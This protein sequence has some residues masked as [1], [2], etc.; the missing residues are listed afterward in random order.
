MH[1]PRDTTRFGLTPTESELETM[2]GRVALPSPELDLYQ[3]AFDAGQRI[4]RR[5]ARRWQAVA[6]SVLVL[7]VAS[8][9]GFVLRSPQIDERDLAEGTPAAIRI[10]Q[11]Q[12]TVLV[13]HESGSKWEE[14]HAD[15]SRLYVGDT[16]LCSK[17]A[18]LTL[19]LADNS[20]VVLTSNS[21][22]ALAHENGGL[23]LA[24]A[25]GTMT[26]D[27]TS[28]HPPFVIDTP[29]GRVHALGTTFTVTVDGKDP[30]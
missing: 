5:S 21:R 19:Q 9:G 7:L 27:L 18:S 12:G 6:A 29:Q 3:A 1:D 26:A 11:V 16:L 4:A 28:P 15:R 13:K 8:I 25:H 24:L 2:L 22:L 14:I 10:D 23:E 17:D 30:R 20:R